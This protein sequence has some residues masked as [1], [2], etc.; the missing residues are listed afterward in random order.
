MREHGGAENA[1]GMAY[2]DS[3][4]MHLSSVNSPAQLSSAQS[5]LIGALAEIIEQQDRRITELENVTPAA[6]APAKKSK[7]S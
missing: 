4:G 1:E 2:L 6:T 5:V 7:K 3:L